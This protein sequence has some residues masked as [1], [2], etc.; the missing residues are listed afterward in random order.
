MCYKKGREFVV[1]WVIWRN[2]FGVVVGKVGLAIRE[3]AVPLVYP[4]M[5]PEV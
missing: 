4:E 5:R 3:K 2:S 1:L